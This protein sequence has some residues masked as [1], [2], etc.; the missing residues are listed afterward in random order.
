MYPLADTAAL[1]TGR[2]FDPQG[3]R[4]CIAA[5]AAADCLDVDYVNLCAVVWKGRVRS[6]PAEWQ[7]RHRGNRGP[8]V[9][10]RVWLR[11][12]RVY[13]AQVDRR[14]VHLERRVYRT[15]L[16][17]RGGSPKAA[18]GSHQN[19]QRVSVGVAGERVS[20]RSD[21]SKYSKLF[22]EVVRHPDDSR[23]LE[24]FRDMCSF[25]SPSGDLR[26]R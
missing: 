19:G 22:N 10:G 7:P 17:E 18:I 16:I 11:S 20:S 3:A 24:R 21:C 26:N 4:D 2:V 25:P 1:A 13:H 15:L 6:P 14:A 8:S 9:R 23:E 5:V 12:Q